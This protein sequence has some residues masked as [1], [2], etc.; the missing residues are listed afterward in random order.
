[1][2]FYQHREKTTI[3]PATVDRVVVGQYSLP[4][5]EEEE[6]EEH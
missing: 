1:L 6:E 5:D 3:K 2:Y 4:R